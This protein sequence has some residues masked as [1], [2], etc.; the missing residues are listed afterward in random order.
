[1][2]RCASWEELW[3]SGSKH[4]ATTAFAT[5]GLPLCRFVITLACLTGC[6]FSSLYDMSDLGSKVE[7]GDI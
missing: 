4:V 3:L 7:S 6:A 5:L 2:V 1:M